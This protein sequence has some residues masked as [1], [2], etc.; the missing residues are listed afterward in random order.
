MATQKEIGKHCRDKGFY[1]KAKKTLCAFSNFQI[2]IDGDLDELQDLA[3]K[4]KLEFYIL[5]GEL[6]KAIPKEEVK[7]IIKDII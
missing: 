3:K 6:K 7:D 4:E 2:F 1:E 5:K